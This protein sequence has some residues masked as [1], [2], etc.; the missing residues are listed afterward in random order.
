MRLKTRKTIVEINIKVQK[1]KL[2]LSCDP[3]RPFL[4][5]YPEDFKSIGQRYLYNVTAALFTVDKLCKQ[6]ECPSTQDGWRWCMWYK[7]HSGIVFH[8]EEWSYIIWKKM[9]TTGDNH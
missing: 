4:G 9:D 3:S 6:A 5:T 8:Q 1:I 2:D 7:G